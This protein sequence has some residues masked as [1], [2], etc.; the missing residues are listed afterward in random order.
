MNLLIGAGREIKLKA[1]EIVYM[2]GEPA[3]ELYVVASGRVRAYC[4]TE[5]G[6][7][8][9]LEVIGNGRIFGDSSFLPGFERKVNIESVVDSRLIVFKTENMIKLCH[10]NADLML[11]LFRHMTE[12]CDYLTHQLTSIVN[13]DSRQ[14][15]ADF[16]L[17]E[18]ERRSCDELSYTHEQIAESTALNRVTVSRILAEFKAACWISSKYGR[19]E[20]KDRNALEKLI[21]E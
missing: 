18:S 16:L 7:S 8:V 9:T 5:T 17:T 14:R 4:V 21:E 10:Q 3:D 2:Q 1:G 12:T 6:K 11:L 13:Y 19:I 20:I 15:I